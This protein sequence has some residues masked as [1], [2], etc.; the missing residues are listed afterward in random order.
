M[1]PQQR[2]H[3]WITLDEIEQGLRIAQTDRRDPGAAD[4]HR[5]MVETH[6]AMPFARLFQGRF[7]YFQLVIFQKPV[8]R[9]LNRR[10]EH[11]DAPGTDIGYRLH[12]LRRHLR[13]DPG[14]VMVARQPAAGHGKRSGQLAERFIGRHAGVLGQ[15]AGA[16]QQVDKRLLPP[17]LGHHMTQAV[18]GIEAQHAAGRVGEQVG[19]GQLHH[20]H[21][22]GWIRVRQRPSPFSE[23]W[24]AR[25]RRPGSGSATHPGTD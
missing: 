11:D 18:T 7:Q 15:I 10:V 9:P 5:L 4:V 12:Q 6:Q 14:L 25:G 17:H 2:P 19:I 23:R 21:G 20:M 8:G 22:A 3:L 13:H 1:P 24:P 16:Q